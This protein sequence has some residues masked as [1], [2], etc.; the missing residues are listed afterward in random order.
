MKNIDKIL[1]AFLASANFYSVAQAQQY[2]GSLSNG[3]KQVLLS[4]SIAAPGV[5]L[6]GGSA[7]ELI[8]PS[9]VSPKPEPGEK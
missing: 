5:Q 9:P 8:P 1:I 4:I 3:E 6:T 2:V 7:N